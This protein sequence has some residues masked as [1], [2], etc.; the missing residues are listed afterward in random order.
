MNS[1][2]KEYP[3]LMLNIFELKLAQKQ[4][5]ILNAVSENR[6]FQPNNEFIPKILKSR[7]FLSKSL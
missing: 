6:Q 7:K 1:S 2:F 3:R 5:S 4:H